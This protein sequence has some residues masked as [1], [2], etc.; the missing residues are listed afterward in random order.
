MTSPTPARAAPGTG[1]CPRCA[2]ATRWTARACEAAGHATT[3]PARYTEASLV[4]DLEERGIGRPSTY[5]AI[6]ATI[7][8]RGYVRKRGTALVPT[9]VAFSVTR[10]MEQ[11]FAELVDYNFTA[12]LEG[13][14]DLVASASDSTDRLQV[15]RAFFYGDADRNFPGLQP[16]VS[17][18]GD[19]DARA[20]ASFPLGPDGFSEGPVPDGRGHDRPA[21]GQVRAVPGARRTAGQRA[22][23]HRRRRAGPGDGRSPARRADR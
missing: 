9:F 15:L 20:L 2:R 7:T 16:L 3:P 17:G 12:R 19:I 5:A 14:L 22:R 13:V 11:H 6:I 18:L 10:L 23:G 1:G 8:D 4:K 21:C